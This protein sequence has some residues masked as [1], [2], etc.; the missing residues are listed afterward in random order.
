MS[1]PTLS[2]T[3]M[4]LRS[5]YQFSTGIYPNIRYNYT[6]GWGWVV[7]KPNDFSDYQIRFVDGILD[8]LGLFLLLLLSCLFEYL[9]VRMILI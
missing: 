9:E 1:P 3:K 2:F 5:G 6:W 4:T 7:A 8:L